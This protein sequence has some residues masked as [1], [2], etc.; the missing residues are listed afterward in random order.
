[1]CLWN[2]NN[3]IILPFFIVE[4]KN[5]FDGKM[6]LKYCTTTMCFHKIVLNAGSA[7]LWQG[8]TLEEK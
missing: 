7:V 1:M 5:Y 6:D 8:E 4:K 3:I 2:K